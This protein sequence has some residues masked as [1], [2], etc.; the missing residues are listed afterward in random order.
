M[1]KTEE[2][3][4]LCTGSDLLAALILLALVVL[5]VAVVILPFLL[6]DGPVRFLPMPWIR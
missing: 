3:R 4:P 1:K 6:S 2:R 5:I